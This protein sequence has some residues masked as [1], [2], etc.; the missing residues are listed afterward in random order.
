ML[1]D[2]FRLFALTLCLTCLGWVASVPALAEDGYSL[3]LRYKPLESSR[4]QELRGQLTAIT[5]PDTTAVPR[6]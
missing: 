4:Q 2:I 1:R 3:W 6:F 5:L